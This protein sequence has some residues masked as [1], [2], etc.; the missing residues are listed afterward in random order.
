MLTSP[1]YARL[2]GYLADKKVGQPTA[3]LNSLAFSL[4]FTKAVTDSTSY[5]ALSNIGQQ[6][7]GV[8]HLRWVR[9][10]LPASR[11]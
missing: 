7:L 3:R 11:A 10:I 2:E 4:G 8:N 5:P 1:W 6:L 9:S